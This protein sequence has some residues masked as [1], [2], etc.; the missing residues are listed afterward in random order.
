MNIPS[1][2]PGI[3]ETL[4]NLAWRAILMVAWVFGAPAVILLY[5]AAWIEE[6]SDRVK[7]RWLIV[8]SERKTERVMGS[9][10]G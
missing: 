4:L 6:L 5:P 9:S 1:G 2:K 10:M 3:N 7:Q 8:R